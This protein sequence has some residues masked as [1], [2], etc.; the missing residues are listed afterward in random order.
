MLI[1]NEMC[2]YDF[3]CSI[4]EN[5]DLIM[6]GLDKHH[7]K[8]ACIAY[9]IAIEMN[10]PN[11]D[12]QDIVLA[13]MMHDISTFSSEEQIKWRK[14]LPYDNDAN[15]YEQIGYE[16]LNNF[17]PLTKAVALIKFYHAGFDELNSDIPIGSYIIHLAD[18]SSMLFEEH[19]DILTQIPE[20]FVKISQKKD[21]F[22][23]EVFAAFSRLVKRAQ[24]R[25]WNLNIIKDEIAILGKGFA[26][27]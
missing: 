8:A 11:D 22:H 1:E 13:A 16:F 17:E 6:P 10:L 26:Q 15:Q 27:S 7:K 3:V 21:M 5:V 4:S 2:I 20:V 25:P 14:T 18:R 9:N 19:R 23:P 12:I 24:K